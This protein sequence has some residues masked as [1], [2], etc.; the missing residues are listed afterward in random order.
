MKPKTVNALRRTLSLADLSSLSISS[1]GPAFSISAAAGVMVGYSGSYSLLAILLIALPFLLSSVVFRLLNQHFPQAGASYHW[2]ARVL[3]ARASRFQGWVVLLAY[4][5]SLPPIV[6]PAAQYTIALVHPQ[7][8]GNAVAQLACGTFWIAFSAVPLL[9]GSRPTAGVTKVFLAVE[10]LFLGAFAAVGIAM[11]PHAHLPRW[12]GSFPVSGILVTMVVATT[13]L[14]GWEIDSYASE[15][16]S[17]PARDPGLGGIIGAVAALLMY[18]ALFPLILSETPLHLLANSPDPMTVWARH[19][20]PYIQPEWSRWILVP[21]LASTAGS[22]WLTSFILTRALYSMGRDRLLPRRF[23]R[24]NP[25]GAPAFSTWAVLGGVWIV[26]VLQLF[27]TSLNTFFSAVL[28]SAGF[29]LTLE[30]ALDNL[31]A[32][33]FLWRIHDLTPHRLGRHSHRFMKFGA[34]FAAVYLAC[35][36]IAFLRFG[37]GLVAPWL[38]AVIAAGMAFGLVF[39]ALP[40]RG[41]STTHVFRHEE[42]SGQNSRMRGA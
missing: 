4:F 28:A 6:L 22:L 10:L 25:H 42:E 27:A 11:L 20:S 9:F 17:K 1:V 31:T 34:L 30:F 18:M 7:W 35:V 16:A 3:G 39:M 36:M 24:V 8:Q 12:R 14:D 38:D 19:L 32:T 21:I 15:E 41:D 29:F 2:S 33:V 37:P 13:I 5:A 23:A 26:L 40:R